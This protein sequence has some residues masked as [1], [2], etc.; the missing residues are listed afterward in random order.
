MSSLTCGVARFNHTLAKFIGAK[1]VQIFD[2]KNIEPK[3]TIL[4]IKISEFEKNEIKK[5]NKF[6]INNSKKYSVF[7]HD[8]NNLEIEKKILKHS[9]E[10]FSGNENI[11]LKIKKNGYDAVS[12]WCPNSNDEKIIFEKRQITFFSFGMAHKVKTIYYKKLKKIMDNSK[13]D[14]SIYLSTALHENTNFE[15]NFYE[16]FQEL[17]KIFKKNI[18]F[19]GFLSDRA[20]FNYLR[21]ADYFLAFFQNGIRE[22]NTSSYFAFENRIPLITNLD[23]SSPD[24]FKHDKNLIDINEIKTLN[25][26]KKQIKNV[27]SSAKLMYDKYYSWDNLVKKLNQN[28]KIK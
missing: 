1:Y 4:S 17:K 27:T 13:I 21:N 25:Y 8:F 11:K 14:Y 3:K 22:N 18:Y 24:K 26:N 12:L 5:L 23:K 19:L 9:C 6:L 20:I 15:E 2:C 7:F 16:A 28:N 10:I